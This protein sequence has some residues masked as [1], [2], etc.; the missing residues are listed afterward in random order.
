MRR[1]LR[2]LL[3]RRCSLAATACNLQLVSSRPQGRRLTAVLARLSQGLASVFPGFGSA[4]EGGD[5]SA[6]PLRPVHARPLRGGV[7][8]NEATSTVPSRRRLFGLLMNRLNMKTLGLLLLVIMFPRLLAFLVAMFVRIVASLLMRLSGRIIR[9]LLTQMA[10]LA[11]D[12][13]SQLIEWLY[14]AWVESQVPTTG[15]VPMSSS[16]SVQPSSQPGPPPTVT[17]A[18]PTRPVGLPH[19]VFVAPSSASQLAQWVGWVVQAA[20]WLRPFCVEPKAKL[21]RRMVSTKLR[22]EVAGW[23]WTLNRRLERR[24]PGDHPDE[25]VCLPDSPVNQEHKVRNADFQFLPTCLNASL[26]RKLP[27]EALVF[28]RAA[29]IEICRKAEG[30]R[31]CTS[32]AEGETNP[33]YTFGCLRLFCISRLVRPARKQV[34]LLAAFGRERRSSKLAGIRV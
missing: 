17:V 4:G 2:A 20:A 29:P 24:G 21:T 22:P 33:L 27:G 8:G 25:H 16:P 15:M 10:L 11:A 18:L 9:E 12:L 30:I 23:W 19:A 14:N 26:C 32:G 34:L 13:E 6:E 3:R 5:P 1:L 31:K 28:S 7:D